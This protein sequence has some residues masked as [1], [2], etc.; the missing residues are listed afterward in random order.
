[1]TI[2]ERDVGGGFL[3][4]RHFGVLAWRLKQ[5]VPSQLRV[6]ARPNPN[7][8]QTSADISAVQ[9]RDLE[10]S[11]DKKMEK[12]G[13]KTRECTRPGWKR[14]ATQTTR[15]ERCWTLA[16]PAT[17]L[18]SGSGIRAASQPSHGPEQAQHRPA[19]PGLYV[20]HPEERVGHKRDL[21]ACVLVSVQRSRFQR[22]GALRTH[23]GFLP[24][25]L[26]LAPAPPTSTRA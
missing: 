4:L 22:D 3:R 12:T 15:A 1:M 14:G 10:L 26:V 7:P 20:S 16:G 23:D 21:P 25:E 18:V 17:M 8:D 11:N 5:V 9:L 24:P 19:D 13:K 6:P 2:S